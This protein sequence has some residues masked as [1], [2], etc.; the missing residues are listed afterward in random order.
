MAPPN[1][2]PKRKNGFKLGS[3]LLGPTLP[4]KNVQRLVCHQS[5]RVWPEIRTTLEFSRG[6][7]NIR[8]PGI[9]QGAWKFPGP[10]NFQALWKIPGA[11]KSSEPWKFPGPWKFPW[12]PTIILY[13]NHFD[14]STYPFNK[15]CGR[16]GHA[17]MQNV[18]LPTLDQHQSSYFK[19]S[20][21]LSLFTYKIKILTS[22]YQS[23]NSWKEPLFLGA[24]HWKFLNPFEQW[25]V[26][27]DDCKVFICDL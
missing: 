5:Q 19:S 7:G 16:V 21:Q 18:S 23:V 1:F 27:L 17:I 13:V 15:N 10:E 24:G 8:D 4:L 6:P 26:F 25:A 20:W 3:N 11:A 14:N 22:E 9:F 12:S 2:S